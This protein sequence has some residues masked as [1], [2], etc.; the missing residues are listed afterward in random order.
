MSLDGER[1]SRVR[2]GAFPS[3]AEARAMV[4]V[5]TR[6]YDW[7]VRIDEL[8]AKDVPPAGAV[9]ATREFLTRR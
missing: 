8:D 2:V 4:A 6:D 7:T 9:R 3:E 5:L 1:I